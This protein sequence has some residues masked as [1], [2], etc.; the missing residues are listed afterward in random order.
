MNGTVL[1]TI[2]ALRFDHVSY[3]DGATDTTPFLDS[4]ASE[5]TFFHRHYS[6]GSGTS[7]SFPGIHASALPLDEG[8]AGLD[9]AHTS[10]AE[11]LQSNSVQTVGIT[12]QTSCSSLFD[13]DVGFDSFQDWVTEDNLDGNSGLVDVGSVKNR[14]RGFVKETPILRFIG[15]TALSMYRTRT[16][17][18]C[19]YRRATEVTD[20]AVSTVEDEI[21][22][23]KP[24]FIWI[25]YMEPHAPYF[26][27]EKFL[28]QFHDGTWT[29]A[30]VNREFRKLSSSAPEI[31][32]GTMIEEASDSLVDAI[33][34]Y[35]AAATK[36]VDEEVRRLFD[37]FDELGV[38]EDTDVYVTADH[39]EELFDHGDLEHRPKMYNEL[40]HVPLIHYNPPTSADTDDVTELTSHLDLAPTIV[41]RMGHDQ[42]EQWRGSPLSPYLDGSKP[43][44]P[45]TRCFSELC[46]TSGL[47]GSIRPDQFTGAITTDRW[48]FIYNKQ[49]GTRELYDLNA[50]PAE[51]NDVGDQH[52]EQ[53]SEFERILESRIESTSEVQKP[54]KLSEAAESR[55]EELGYVE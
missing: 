7:T 6:T 15:Q 11:I 5:G 23:G 12:A 38:F 45:R 42:P 34:E 14:V 29:T 50:D 21:D 47:G 32:D 22:P 26:P 1:I 55:L 39:G 2:D 36:Y 52:R 19:P 24:F 49:L 13:Y 54:V 40:I 8:Y 28:D 25:H 27:P 18:P 10:V 37:G 17:S 31:A 3:T 16:G 48:K 53:K 30:R 33:K 20:T 35:Y 46:H 9:S 43:P 51:L 4:L 44:S 41:D